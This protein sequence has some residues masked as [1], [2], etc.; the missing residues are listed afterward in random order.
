MAYPMF[1][2]LYVS[3][4]SFMKHKKV[5][6]LD[7]SP[8]ASLFI[9]KFKIHSLQ[10]HITI[11]IISSMSVRLNKHKKSNQHHACFKTFG[12]NWFTLNLQEVHNLI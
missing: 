3:L 5:G 4:I 9:W 1:G 7:R 12:N 11:H 6:G 2:F 10:E 8:C